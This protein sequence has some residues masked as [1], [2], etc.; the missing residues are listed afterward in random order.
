W[1]KVL[2]GFTAAPKLAVHRVGRPT[3]RR[4][5]DALNAACR[6]LDLAARVLISPRAPHLQRHD[7]LTAKPSI[8][9][10]SV[11]TSTAEGLG[12]SSD[13]LTA[14]W[15]PKFSVNVE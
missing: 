3:A 14:R 12:R 7:T 13:L 8:D 10:P 4:H 1:H 2:Q 6:H 15:L 9:L 5:F 11:G